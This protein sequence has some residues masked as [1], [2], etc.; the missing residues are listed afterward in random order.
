[1]PAGQL[2]AI[3]RTGTGK[4]VTRKIRATG[5]IPGI[6]YG[7]GGEPVLITVDPA[8]LLKALDGEKKRNSVID[9][10]VDPAVGKGKSPSQEIKVMLRDWQTD[11]LRGD[12]THA[13]FVR[14]RLDQDVHATVPLVLVGKA[15][16]VKLGGTLHMV[17]RSLEVACTPDKIPVK[18]EVNVEK[19]GMGDSIKVSDL[20]LA[21]GVR[22][23]V[24][25]SQTVCVV[26]IPKAEKVEAEAEAPVEGAAAAP[27]AG[28]AEGAKA[29]AGGKPAA[30]AAPAAGAKPG[31][32]P[33]KGGDKPAEKKK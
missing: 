12:L 21:A 18:I 24:E 30:G 28:A 13:D 26:T 22:P 14:V 5:K 23:L 25:A 29:A 8:E 19:L 6:V 15:E 10:K 16:G 7:K 31:A 20:P 2:S 4:S 27:A 17:I 33:A 9:L 11:P 32:A 3:T 1:M